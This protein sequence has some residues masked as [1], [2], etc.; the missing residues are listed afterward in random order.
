[1]PTSQADA[2]FGVL[3]QVDIVGSFDASESLVGWGDFWGWLKKSANK[4]RNKIFG[5]GDG[6]GIKPGGGSGASVP[7]LDLTVAGSAVVLLL[8]GVAYMV[9]RR[10][11]QQ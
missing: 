8:G 3:P 2:D 4:V 11:E 1:M 5:G 10:R 6:G 9:S 7:E